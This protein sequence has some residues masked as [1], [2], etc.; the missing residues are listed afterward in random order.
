MINDSKLRNN[1]LKGNIIVILITKGLSILVSLLYV[2]LLLGSMDTDNYAVWLTLTSLVSWIALFDIGLGN[3]LRNR[4]SEALA[5]NDY[6]LARTYVSTAYCGVF[7]VAIG[8]LLCFTIA[9]PFVNWSEILNTTAINQ[10]Q[11]SFLVTIVFCGFI[12]NFVFGLINS[13]LY[14]VQYPAM[15]SLITFTGQVVSFAIVYILVKSHS[16]SNIVT[17]GTI[18]AIIPPLTY[19]I[20]SLIL[21][22]S[23]LKQISPKYKFIE[24]SKIKD[25]LSL[26]IKFFILQIITIVLFQTNNIIII[27][28]VDKDAVVV[29]NILYKYLYI[30][31]TI[32]A[33][34]CAPIWSATTEA[35]VKN[36]FNWIKMIKSKLIKISIVFIIGG[37]AMVAL[38]KYVFDIWLG[39]NHPVILID[40]TLLMLL[41]C[42]FMIL[43]SVYGYIING[44]GKLKLQLYVTSILALIYLPVAYYWGIRYGLTGIL[45]AMCLVGLINFIWSKA[46]LTRILSGKARGIWVQ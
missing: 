16:I 31:V 14:A 34:I 2:P 45:I 22:K 1:R 15:S 43:Y 42:S 41:Y 33:M 30:L 7:I 5:K 24:F 46:Q 32:F 36:D 17:L 28:A 18:I 11:L 12:M 10:K 9:N 13:V 44:I 29:Y 19:V 25:I 35:Y 3:G 40:N 8:L 6:I 23:K 37:L 21:F 27:H 38:S 39:S 4:L 26:G 20:Y